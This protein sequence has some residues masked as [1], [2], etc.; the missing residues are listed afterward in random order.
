VI[1]DWYPLILVPLIY[2]ELAPLNRA[3]W[4]GQYFD[5]IILGWEQVL[6]GGQPS[7]SLAVAAPVLALSE[8]LH[9]AYL[10]YYLIIYVPPVVLWLR[11]RFED[12]RAGVFA[13]MLAFFAHYVFFIFF[14]VQGPRYL[15]P[16]PG[17]SLASGY[18]YG[19]A[20]GVLEAGSSQGAAFPSSHVGVAMAQTVIAF[21][22]LPRFAPVLAVMTVLLAV[23]AVYGGFHYAI[24]ATAGAALGAIVALA[25]LRLD[26]RLRPGPVRT[27]A[28]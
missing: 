4:G 14:P 5:D 18:L 23:G 13:L 16:A 25:G 10:S 22:L 11:K 26:A 27:A 17:G 21:K 24:D 9:G 12:F 2:L 7:R 1:A 19:I 20:H 3:I 28:R 15:F 6:F 8:L